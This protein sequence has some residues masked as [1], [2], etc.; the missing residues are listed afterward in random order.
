MLSRFQSIFFLRIGVRSGWST[1]LFFYLVSFALAAHAAIT[2]ADIPAPPHPSTPAIIPSFL[3]PSSHPSLLNCSLFNCKYKNV[4]MVPFDGA[5]HSR[6]F[7]DVCRVTQL[8]LKAFSLGKNK[9][10]LGW[11]GQLEGAD[12]HLQHWRAG[13]YRSVPEPTQHP[14]VQ[15]HRFCNRRACAQWKL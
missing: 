11:G 4:Q 3:S 9:R 13:D 7:S 14:P 15:P 8:W 6:R 10:G 12:G 1:S 5:G 2:G